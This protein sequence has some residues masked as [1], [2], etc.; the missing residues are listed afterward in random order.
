MPSV[1]CYNP[2]DTYDQNSAEKF[3]CDKMIQLSNRW[4]LCIRTNMSWNRAIP[5]SIMKM[6]MAVSFDH[7]MRIPKQHQDMANWLH[8]PLVRQMERTASWHETRCRLRLWWKWTCA[9]CKPWLCASW[10]NTWRT[11]PS[12]VFLGEHLQR[13][14]L[15]ENSPEQMQHG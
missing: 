10:P 4:T 6:G 11:P 2:T 3:T 14:R 13:N 7:Q 9:C 15:P 5:Q 1:V 8:Q 12:N